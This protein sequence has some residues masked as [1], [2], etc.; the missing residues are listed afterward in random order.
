M[1]PGVG[2]PNFRMQYES[3]NISNTTNANVEGLRCGRYCSNSQK[4]NAFEKEKN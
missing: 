1:M 3:Y 4:W 2:V